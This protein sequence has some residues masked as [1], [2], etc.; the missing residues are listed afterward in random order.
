VSIYR[1]SE[2]RIYIVNVLGDD[3][4][5]LGAAELD[6][7]FG[8]PGDK[9]FVGDFD[10]D[11]ID[12]VGSHRESTGLVY[13]R[14]RQSSGLADLQFVYG[15]PRDRI[16]AGDWTGD[17]IDT[18]AVFRPDDRSWYFRYANSSGLADEEL[19]WGEPSWLPIA[20]RFEPAAE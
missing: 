8:D 19:V 5:G 17:G 20:G 12:T 10:D 11:G 3:G 9:L 14:N 1:P 16:V 7:A 4:G 13:F 18:P 6:F 2:A 15:N